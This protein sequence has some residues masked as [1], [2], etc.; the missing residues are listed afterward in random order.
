[1]KFQTRLYLVFVLLI[2]CTTCL[3]LGL[4][5]VVARRSLLEEMRSKVLT[6]AVT[7]ARQMDVAT[8]SELQST[9]DTHSPQ[10]RKL[11]SKLLEVQGANQR[12]DVYTLYVYTMRPTHEGREMEVVIDPIQNKTFTEFP[13][14]LYPKGTKSGI[15]QHLNEPWS[16]SHWVNEPW[17]H[18]IAGYAPVYD[19][20]GKYVGTIGI[21]LSAQ[22]VSRELGQ[23]QVSVGATMALTLIAGLI[24]AVFLSHFATHALSQISSCVQHIGEGD[25]KARVPVESE[26]EFGHLAIAINQMAKGLEEHERLKLGFIRY[27]SKPIMEKILSSDITFKGERRRIT[28]LFSDIREFTSFSERIDPEEVVSVLNEYLEEMFK[29][30]FAH[31]GTLDK[32]IG[33]GLMVEFGAPL[34]DPS[35]E[36]NAVLTAIEMQKAL[37]AL[38]DRWQAKGRPRLKMG[39]GIHSGLAVVGNIGTDQR[40]DYTAI[41][42]TVNVAARLEAATKE[43]N[44][45]I[46][47]SAATV[48]QVAGLFDFKKLGPIQLPGR[49]TPIEVFSLR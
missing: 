46:L 20:Q 28:V 5:Y 33:D 22:S 14:Q 29:V 30:I 21:N 11:V 4:V 37:S 7:A 43:H 45:S 6:M 36:K 34:D 23:L 38:C 27:V 8:L 40:M 17:G 16:P 26:D 25:L 44:V 18:F 9:R 48:E 12:D 42:D 39:I 41:G 32:I 1:M 3:G 13:E 35:Q 2:F 31:N 47:V 19:S 15:L 24:A 49:G 10:F